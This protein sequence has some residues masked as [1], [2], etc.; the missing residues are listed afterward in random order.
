MRLCVHGLCLLLPVLACSSPTAPDLDGAWGGTGASLTIT[1]AG[2][3][4]QYQCGA[5]TI[6]PG[7]TVSAEGEFSGTGQHYVGGGPVPAEGRPP[8]P[9]RYAGRVDGSVFTVTVT[10]TDLDQALGPYRLVR[11]GP[12]VTEICF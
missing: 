6:D 1:A 3:T 5:G 9:A 8:H 12:V 4:I 2:G 11:G 7:W 10:L